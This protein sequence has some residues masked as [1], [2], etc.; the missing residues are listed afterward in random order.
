MCH[1]V[2]DPEE[3]KLHEWVCQ[4]LRVWM[5]PEIIRTMQAGFRRG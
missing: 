3:L 4:H 1:Q 5:K 2:A